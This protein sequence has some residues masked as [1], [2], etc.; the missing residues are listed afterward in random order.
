MT[1][2]MG[3]KNY[4]HMGHSHFFNSTCHISENNRQGHATLPFLKIDKADT[5][6]DMRVDTRQNV[7]FKVGV[8]FIPSLHNYILVT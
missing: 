5:Q 4:S 2:D 8:I 7:P 6:S 1:C 3:A